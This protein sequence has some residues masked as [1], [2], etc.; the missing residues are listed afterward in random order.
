MS[1]YH[2]KSRRNILLESVPTDQLYQDS[3]EQPDPRLNEEYQQIQ[4]LVKQEKYSIR[5]NTLTKEDKSSKG[6]V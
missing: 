3:N 4:E 2:Q 6:E 1:T 5:A